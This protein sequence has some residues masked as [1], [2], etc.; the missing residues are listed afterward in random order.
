MPNWELATLELATFPDW[1][2]SPTASAYPTS[3]LRA[4][5][6]HHRDFIRSVISFSYFARHPASMLASSTR[7]GSVSASSR[8]I[9]AVGLP[10]TPFTTSSHTARTCGIEVCWKL[11]LAGMS[12]GMVQ[13]P[14]GCYR[15][16][17]ILPISQFRM[18]VLN[19]EWPS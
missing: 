8:S 16:G 9:S 6:R 1:Q 2:H 5:L 17:I 10:L 11:L 15:W 18:T 7:S 3:R 19:F 14:W 12:V 13:V 4:I